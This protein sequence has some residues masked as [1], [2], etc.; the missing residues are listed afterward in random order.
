MRNKLLTVLFVVQILLGAIIVGFWITA[1]HPARAEDWLL[2]KDELARCEA[3][4][5][6]WEEELDQCQTTVEALKKIEE[7]EPYICC[8]R[9]WNEECLEPKDNVCLKRGKCDH[10]WQDCSKTHTQRVVMADSVSRAELRFV[11][12]TPDSRGEPECELLTS[13]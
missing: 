13:D 7:D 9:V 8:Y 6:T 4:V 1:C 12:S 2:C 10:D 11:D 3:E 5:L